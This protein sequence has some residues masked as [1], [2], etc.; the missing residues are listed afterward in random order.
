MSKS[1][2]KMTYQKTKAEIFAALSAS[3]ISMT[4][5][6]NSSFGTISLAYLDLDENL[7]SWFVSI[8]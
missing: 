2:R 5:G 3:L 6:I 7:G 4:I 8:G 1:L